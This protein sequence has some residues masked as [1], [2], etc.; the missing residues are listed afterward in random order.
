MSGCGYKHVRACVPRPAGVIGSEF[1]PWTD[2]DCTG[3]GLSQVDLDSVRVG[4]E[5]VAK[6]G[7][8]QVTS[9]RVAPED[10]LCLDQRDV[11]RALVHQNAHLPW[12]STLLFDQPM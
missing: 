5:N 7:H 8:A 10:D 3:E 4:V 9:S 12:T 11:V 6:K 1:D 2:Q